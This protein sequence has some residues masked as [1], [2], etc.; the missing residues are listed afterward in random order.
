MVKLQKLTILQEN[1][2]MNIV[3][4]YIRRAARMVGWEIGSAIEN[5]VWSI[6]IFLVLMCCGCLGC[7]AVVWQIMFHK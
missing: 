1:L 5:V 7:G 2:A 3:E 6:G 4:P